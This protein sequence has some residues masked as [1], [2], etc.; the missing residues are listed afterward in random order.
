G[1]EQRRGTFLVPSSMSDPVD[2]SIVRH[3]P[4]MPEV[5]VHYLAPAA[6]QVVL[7]ATVGAG[8]HAQMLARVL[9][10]GGPLIR[11][12]RDAAMLA[13]A[14]PRLEGLPVTLVQRNFDELPQVLHELGIERVDGVLADLG[15]CTDQLSDPARGLSFQEDGPLDMRLDPSDGEPA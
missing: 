12:D 6:G 11:L 7:D 3:V 8:G 2:A 14:R 13:L 10:P 15:F 5:V 1:P 9:A 4:V